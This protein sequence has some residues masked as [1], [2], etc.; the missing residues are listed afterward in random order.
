MP[1]QAYSRH[2]EVILLTLPHFNDSVVKKE[3]KKKKSTE[4]VAS[5][6]TRYPKCKTLWEKA[7]RIR[8]K[9]ATQKEYKRKAGSK[10][11]KAISLQGPFPQSH[12]I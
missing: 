7:V 6:K 10:E 3:K 9:S 5:L 4:L 12:M 11:R 8:E 2:I 1:L